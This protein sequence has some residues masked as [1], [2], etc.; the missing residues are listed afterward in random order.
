MIEQRLIN[1]INSGRVWAFVGS[2]ASANAGV[3][4][5]QD[6]YVQA[7]RDLTGD[8]PHQTHSVA[9][10]PRLFGQL[11]RQHGRSAVISQ[12]A[13]QLRRVTQPGPVHRLLAAWP[14]ASYVTTNYD[15]LMDCALRDHSAWL[16]I[17]NTPPETKKISGDVSNVVWHP[18][19]IVDAADA[20]SR[21]V[22]SQDDYDN[23]YPAGSPVLET[24]KALLRMRSIVF[25]G[26]GFNDPDL[27]QLLK[28]VARLSDPGQPAY[29]FLSGVNAA[30]REE[31]RTGYN[32]VT[33]PYDAPESDHS[34]L[35]T[36]LRHYSHFIV[37]RN[38]TFGNTPSVPPSYDPEVTSLIVQN[39]LHSGSMVVPHSTQERV[40]R[41]SLLA[42][43]STHGPLT[44]ADLQRQVLS[45][46]RASTR[47][48]FQS[49]LNVL[50]ENSL[51]ARSGD[52]L[53]LTQ[54]ALD[55]TAQRRASAQLLFEQFFASIQHRVSA[56]I[57]NGPPDAVKRV[58]DVAAAFF[59]DICKRRG[60]AI[61]QNLSGGP[62]EHLQ[63]RAVA[64]LQELPN[65]FPRCQS[66][67]ETHA[68]ANVVFGVLSDPETPEKVYL[69]SLTQAYF[70][71]HIAGVEEE[72]IAIR[73]QLLADTV[74]VL[75]SH[76]VIVLLAQGCTAHEHAV[77]LVRL[78]G[79]AQAVLVATDLILVETTEHL[80]WAMKEVASPQGA[81]SLQRAFDVVRGASGQ[82]NSFL[83]GYAECLAKGESESFGQYIMAALHQKDTGKL[84]STL[85]RDAIS[86]YGVR[87]DRVDELLQSDH[88]FGAIAAG[89]DARIKARRQE[90]GSYK[91]ERQVNAEAQIVAF[92]TGI[93]SGEIE[94]GVDREAAQA[95]FLT[96]S[97]ILDGLEGC[98][99]RI[100]MA[101]EGLY[102]WLLST[103][104]FTP[105][106]AANVFDHLLL[107]LMESGMQFVPADRIA[108]AFA[109]IVQAGRE[110]M[111]KVVSEYRMVVESHYGADHAR[112]FSQIDDL[113]VVDAAEF[114]SHKLLREQE[115]LL[116]I[117]EK[118]RRDA[119]KKLKAMES[120][121][122]SVAR[123]QRRQREK[124]KRRAAQSRPRTKKEK[125]RERRRKAGN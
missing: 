14:F 67:V 53:A 12:V 54:A 43:L 39:A 11:I 72:S 115:S 5:W 108:R 79:E 120:L 1:L 86:S 122:E 42:A 48:A 109:S 62:D 34:E 92:V 65:W 121:Q 61:A 51:V 37:D 123:Y 63:R 81:T 71:K 3:P 118:R 89:L 124:Q 106:M 107:E 87:V 98:P 32:V 116:A 38:I 68:L 28:L 78:L 52:R 94:A 101:P 36:V 7:A 31:L 46:S 16:S 117:E 75:D 56:Y 119:E 2:G 57:D 33:I 77:E 35:L 47:N 55:L 18:H 44:E 4:T 70:G 103:K 96:D 13:T 88:A 24:L 74:F 21:L 93:R 113:L 112:L 105:E 9:A 30:R 58:S 40:M 85:V 50:V 26:F 100:C 80:E 82:T 41:A 97:R 17:G 90:Y 45:A 69:G 49:S 114:L 83:H 22:L 104:H 8:A 20:T 25:F 73:R 27:G 59:Q 84:T 76:F 6:L 19:G 66:L 91:H 23:I 60:L 29:A 99:Q 110:Q 64:L 95:F 111:D 125:Q 102:Q 15:T 10:L